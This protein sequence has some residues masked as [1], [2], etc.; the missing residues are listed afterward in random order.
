MVEGDSMFNQQEVQTLLGGAN[1]PVDLVD[2]RK[3]TND[4]GLSSGMYVL[5]GDGESQYHVL[6][7]LSPFRLWTLS[8]R[9][10]GGRC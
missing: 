10:N 2:L 9:S 1:S 4:G 5:L 6:I 8:I 3:H 7:R